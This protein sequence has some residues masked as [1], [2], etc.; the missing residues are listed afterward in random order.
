ME[1]LSDYLSFGFHSSARMIHSGIIFTAKAS[2]LLK[3]FAAG[4]PDHKQAAALLRE[5]FES[6]GATYIKLGQFI[7]SAP[8]LFPEEYVTEMQK[9]LDSVRPVSFSDIRR[10]VEKD[11]GDSIQ[12]L[13]Y[14]FDEKPLASASIAQV[15]AAIT[16]EGLDVVVKVQRPDIQTTLKTD[17]QIL[18]LLTR[19]LEWITPEFK[20]SGLSGM[21]SE[22]QS[23]ILQEIDFI[24]EAANIEEFES[25]LLETGEERACVPRVYHTLSTQRVLTMERFYGMPITSEEGLR[26]YSEN[27]RKVLNDALEIWFSSLAKKGFFHAD[28][29]AGNLMILKDGRIGFLD[30]GIVGRI[31]PNVWRGMLLFTQGLGMG[32]PRLVAEGLI[33]MDSTHA[34]V[35]AEHLA[36]Q[37]ESVFSEIESLYLAMLDGDP[38]NFDESKINHM[39]FELKAVSE[40][41]GLKIPREFALLMKQML[42]FDRYVKTMAPEI[43]L[44]RD[45][46]KFVTK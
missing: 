27:P 29:H 41:N 19:V 22:F 18:G 42:Y 25:Y 43:N 14:S 17:M 9:C 10:V 35:K 15:H 26:R 1:T 44:F 34:D 7:A 20:K 45:T 5:S 46:Q 2:S 6:L 11:L 33:A 30:F 40:K 28:V 24:Q 8:S 32:E 12:N 23:S 3:M 38:G 36:S 21:F 37:L 31:S 4:K 39:M 13:F 16:K